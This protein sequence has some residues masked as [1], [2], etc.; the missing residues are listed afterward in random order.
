MHLLLVYVSL[1]LVQLLLEMLLLLVELCLAVSFLCAQLRL[2]MCLL[3][4]HF[5]LN[6]FYSFL[7]LYSHL[8]CLLQLFSEHFDVSLQAFVHSPL[9]LEFH[10]KCFDLK[11]LNIPFVES[12]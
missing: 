10:L 8:L 11:A 6:I 4:V 3:F 5:L 9:S 1:F 7:L 2:T 12:S